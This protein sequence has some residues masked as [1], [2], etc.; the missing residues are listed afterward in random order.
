MENGVKWRTHRNKKIFEREI[1]HARTEK[2]GVRWRSRRNEKIVEGKST[3]PGQN[4][5]D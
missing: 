2:H 4:K 3:T 5:T 1:D